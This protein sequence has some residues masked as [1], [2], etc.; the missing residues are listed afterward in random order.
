MY[1]YY[2]NCPIR[3]CTFLYVLDLH[4]IKV[5]TTLPV[6]HVTAHPPVKGIL[7]VF[8]IAFNPVEHHAVGLILCPQKWRLLPVWVR[9]NV[10]MVLTKSFVTTL[11]MVF[12]NLR[13]GGDLGA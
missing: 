4:S 6:T 7:E 9:S 2:N 8:G 5:P 3:K 12:I 11:Y 13:R 1:K 10:E